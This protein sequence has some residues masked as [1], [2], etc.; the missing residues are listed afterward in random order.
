MA[1][2]DGEDDDL[3]GGE[4]EGKI[5]FEVFQKESGD[6]FDGADGASVDDDCLR[7]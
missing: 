1:V 6:S 3:D 4:P 5:S 7:V 2:G